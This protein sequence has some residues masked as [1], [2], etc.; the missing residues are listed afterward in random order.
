MSE[1]LSKNRMLE[2]RNEYIK[3]Y[4]PDM[5]YI[6]KNGDPSQYYKS[7]NVDSFDGVILY[8]CECIN[9]IQD[10]D[11]NKLLEHL[12]DFPVGML[13]DVN[14]LYEIHKVH[15]LITLVN[16]FKGDFYGGFINILEQNG[17]YYDDIDEKLYHDKIMKFI[18][19]RYKVVSTQDGYILVVKY[20]YLPTNR[21]VFTLYIDERVANIMNK[22]GYGKL[23]KEGKLKNIEASLYHAGGCA[24][25]IWKY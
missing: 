17:F 21:H 10:K 6:M 9:G 7:R 16:N 25:I 13:F 20:K 23:G 19:T 24:G 8:L 4:V 12:E 18:D 22:R 11:K 14:A 3:L 1:I 15:G 5:D 2:L